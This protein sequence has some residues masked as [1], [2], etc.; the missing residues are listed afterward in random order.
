M[1]YVSANTGWDRL[2]D[3][4]NEQDGPYYFGGWEPNYPNQVQVEILLQDTVLASQIRVAQHPFDPVSGDINISAAGIDFSLTLSGIDG[5]Q[6]YTF[7]PPVELD[8]FTVERNDVNSNIVEVL[9]CT[10]P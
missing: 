8:A 5:W 4:V 7:D 1:R 6:A 10:E 2:Y 3:L 9:V